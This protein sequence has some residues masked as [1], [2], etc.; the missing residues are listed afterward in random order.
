MQLTFQSRLFAFKKDSNYWN[1][2]NEQVERSE[3]LFF[4]L[5]QFLSKPFKK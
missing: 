4:Q 3:K 1:N 5:A 2:K